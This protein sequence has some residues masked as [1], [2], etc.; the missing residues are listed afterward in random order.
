MAIKPYSLFAAPLL[1]ATSLHATFATAGSSY[2]SHYYYPA[3]SSSSRNAAAASWESNLPH[4]A[5]D[6]L[7]VVPTC[8]QDC[9]RSFV[10]VSFG[11]SSD[12]AASL[13]CICAQPGELGFTAGEGAIQC[14]VGAQSVGICSESEASRKFSCSVEVQCCQGKKKER[15]AFTNGMFQNS[16]EATGGV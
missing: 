16:L 15:M 11:C 1:I 6:V 5:D 14:L 10:K 13:S 9:F 2:K 3:S 7:R 12:A 4:L 8:A